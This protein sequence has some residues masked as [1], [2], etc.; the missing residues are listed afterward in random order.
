MPVTER[1]DHKYFIEFRI[2]TNSYNDSYP[3]WK[4]NPLPGVK[5]FKLFKFTAFADDK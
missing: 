2:P 5:I 3:K 1:S 4:L